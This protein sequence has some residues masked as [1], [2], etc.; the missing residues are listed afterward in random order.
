MPENEK[1]FAWLSDLGLTIHEVLRYGFGGLLLYAVAALCAPTETK[2]V[3]EALGTTISVIL[4]FTL[5]AAIYAA[6]R[7]ILG[8][9]LL[10]RAH[11]WLHIKLSRWQSGCTCRS[12]YFIDGWP[13]ANLS[14]ASAM[15]A[16]RTV[17][18][19][20]EFDQIKQ[21]RF[22]L[23]HS[24]LHMLYVAFFVLAIT[25]VVLWIK[26]PTGT[27]VSPWTMF[28]VALFFSASGFVGNVHL[29]RQE[30]KVLLQID[31]AAVE[32]ILVNAQ[33]IQVGSHEAN[34]GQ[35]GDAT[36]HP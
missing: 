32:N 27:L 21:R 16:F 26:N 5:G 13:N 15:E 7:P 2:T 8:E 9:F 4:A 18:D 30:C 22:Y 34:A 33:F 3:L 1:K 14:I 31:K 24:E 36:G 17:R 11:E 23:Q 6:Y 19:S 12:A 35:G 10:Y 25:A 20:K 28:V 29:C